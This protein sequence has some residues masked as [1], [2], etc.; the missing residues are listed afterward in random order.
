MNPIPGAASAADPAFFRRVLGHYPT[1]VSIVTGLDTARSPVGMA[2]G[3]FTSLSL[4]PPLVA[5]M[6][7]RSSSTWPLLR[8]SGSFCINV[9][10]AD[11]E[12]QC[13]AFAAPGDRFAGLGWH[14]AGS[15]S[16]I[17][18]G[19]VAYLDCRLEAEHPGGD[20][21]I[22][23]GRVIDLGEQSSTLPLLF[24]RGGYG[25][26][27]PHSSSS[28]DPSF[29][30]QLRLVD[31]ARPL[32][33]RA[34]ERTGAQIVAATCDGQTMTVLASA[35]TPDDPDSPAAAVG[36][37]LPVS[38]PVGIWWAAY[39]NDL[40][41]QRW[42]STVAAGPLRERYTYALDAIHA[43]GYC[44]GMPAVYRQLAHYVGAWER[45]R[46]PALTAGCRPVP[47]RP[48]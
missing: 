20:H 10:A 8:D 45:H 16:P 3:S 26:F 47:L 33:E 19:A 24:H 43:A 5:F 27:T 11:Q 7:A 29:R 21:V 28:R 22:V 17:L 9:L 6:P 31:R 36:A 39:A 34:A 2:V 12:Q 23:V 35:G 44:R 41:R 38:A 25:Q 37:T 42:L 48:H 32:M 46:R 40:E 18:D 14:P 15:G 30:K 13:R 4:D 1:G